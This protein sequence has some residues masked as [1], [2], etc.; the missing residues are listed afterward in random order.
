MKLRHSQQNIVMYNKRNDQIIDNKSLRFSSKTHPKA[1]RRD[2]EVIPVFSLRIFKT[3]SGLEKPL[4]P[5]VFPYHNFQITTNISPQKT[6]N[7]VWL[8][9]DI[10]SMIFCRFV[11]CVGRWNMSAIQASRNPLKMLGIRGNSTVGIQPVGSSR[12]LL[13]VWSEEVWCP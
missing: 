10:M 11:C 4:R 8:K 2:Y 9:K 13:G 3:T 7:P 5:W 6:K 1:L 12:P